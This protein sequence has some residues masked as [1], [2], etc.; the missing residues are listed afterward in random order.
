MAL[1]ATGY[2]KNLMAIFQDMK[3]QIISSQTM[4]V[5]DRYLK[6]EFFFKLITWSVPAFI[7][8][9]LKQHF[10]D[11]SIKKKSEWCLKIYMRV[12]HWWEIRHIHVIMCIY[13]VSEKKS[14]AKFKV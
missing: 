2:H 7:F 8:F 11:G 4:A 6:S 1:A 9:K 10:E 12:L 5:C 3:D 13:F 14:I